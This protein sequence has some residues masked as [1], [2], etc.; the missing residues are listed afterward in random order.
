MLALSLLPCTEGELKPFNLCGVRLLCSAPSNWRK[1]GGIIKPFH[2][3]YFRLAVVCRHA[4]L[5]NCGFN[6]MMP[7]GKPYANGFQSPQSI[8]YGS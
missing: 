4:A 7:E 6:P 1:L 8:P 3:D 5:S 2:V